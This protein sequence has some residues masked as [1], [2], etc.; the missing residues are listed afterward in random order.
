M[1]PGIY[2]LNRAERWELAKAL[3]DRADAPSDG[4]AAF[5][6]AYPTATDEMVHSAA[7]HVYVDGPEAVV[8]WLADA[9]LFLRDPNHSLCSATSWHLLYHV[10]NWHLLEALMPHGRPGV[11]AR[12]KDIKELAAQGDFE[13]VRHEAEQLEEMFGATVSPP[14]V[15]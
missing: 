8:D 12:L 14:S 1:R 2:N 15:D 10:Y 4:K 5:R 6:R 3:M 13:A 7:F 9:E 11:L